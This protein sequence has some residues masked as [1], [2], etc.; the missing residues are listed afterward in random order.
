MSWLG[1]YE[2]LHDVLGRHRHTAQLRPLWL[3]A[4]NVGWLLANEHTCWLTER[5]T[6]LH[7]DAKNRLH[8]ARGPALRFLD[9][10]S[11]YAWKGVE[12]PHWVIS[13]P[14]SVTLQAID[15]EP[16]G[17]VRRCM[18]EVMTLER[19]IAAGGATIVARC[20][21][22]T[23]WRKTWWGDAWAA[24][25]VIN[26]TPEQDGTFK[27]YFLQVPPHMSSARQAVAWTYGLRE[28][29]YAGLALRT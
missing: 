3:L 26:G 25:E 10:C 28:W 23:L 13:H 20:S 1:V 27:R 7:Y 12:V 19:F 6:A 21:A 11:Y 5:P 16:N 9:G 14:D 29:Q 2:F 22:G 17:R 18:I 4:Q 24:V 8:N 15:D